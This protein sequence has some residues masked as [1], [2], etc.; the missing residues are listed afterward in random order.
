MGS[1]PPC[2]ILWVAFLGGTSG[3][4]RHKETN[5]LR[6][7]LREMSL[8]QQHPWYVTLAGDVGT[9]A[10]ESNSV[11]A[12]HKACLLLSKPMDKVLIR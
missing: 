3:L 10:V 2:V 9:H 5:E 8:K 4:V 1:K 12:E 11:V 7:D 6:N